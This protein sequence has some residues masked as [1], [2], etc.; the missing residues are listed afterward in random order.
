MYSPTSKTYG[1]AYGLKQHRQ[2]MFRSCSIGSHCTYQTNGVR[3]I[4][5][6]LTKSRRSGTPIEAFYPSFQ[7]SP[8][9]C[10][11]QALREYEA[12]SQEMRQAG[13]TNSLFISVRKSYIPVK[14]CTIG[15]WIKRVM[16]D[17]GVDTSIFS[18]HSTR[19][20]RLPKPRWGGVHSRHSK[21]SKLELR[22][23]LL[24]LLPQA[25]LI[26]IFWPWG[27]E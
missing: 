11:I 21:S 17:S 12:R 23:H 20:L 13:A 15:K 8:K 18:A 22:S 25:N 6:G 19:E 26:I 3:S 24:S 27:T 7:E 10:P 4:I 5:P 1:N 2:Q 9:L 16:A 14:P